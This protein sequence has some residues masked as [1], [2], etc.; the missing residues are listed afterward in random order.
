[1]K[2]KV[3]LKFPNWRVGEN[4]IVDKE[5]GKKVRHVPKAENN[6]YMICMSCGKPNGTRG[7]IYYHA[8]VV[9]ESSDACEKIVIS[10]LVKLGM[11]TVKGDTL[12]TMLAV[13]VNMKPDIYWNNY[14]YPLL[15]S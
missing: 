3:E 5:F 10:E 7:W 13:K 6:M 8:L 15:R 2:Q 1:M 12:T 14:T 9:G 11:F 4:M